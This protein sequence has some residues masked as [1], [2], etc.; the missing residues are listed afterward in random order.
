MHSAVDVGVP[1]SPL[2]LHQVMVELVIHAVAEGFSHGMRA[3]LAAEFIAIEGFLQNTPGLLSADMPAQSGCRIP[4][5]ATEQRCHRV[6]GA[7]QQLRQHLQPH[8]QR[9]S[10]FRVQGHGTTGGFPGLAALHVL[11]LHGERVHDL[12]MLKH[13]EDGQRQQLRNAKTC[14]VPHDEQRLVPLRKR[15]AKRLGND[16]DFLIRQWSTPSHD[17]PL[18]M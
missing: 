6:Q 13:I 10:G 17:T 12:P 5:S 14:A 8:A 18:H 2:G 11:A 1:H 3:Q 16:A 4:D 15:P 9:G 7:L